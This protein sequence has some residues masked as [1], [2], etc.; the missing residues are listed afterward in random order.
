M[1]NGPKKSIL[2]RL[3][4]RQ[5]LQLLQ[6]QTSHNL[7]THD[8]SVFGIIPLAYD[9]L[10]AVVL[11]NLWKIVIKKR[12]R[13]LATVAA[14]PRC[15]PFLCSSSAII[16]WL[17]GGRMNSGLFHVACIQCSAL[18][19]TTIKPSL[20]F[21]QSLINWS[22]SMSLLIDSCASLIQNFS[23]TSTS[24]VLSSLSPLGE[25]LYLYYNAHK[26]SAF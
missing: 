19:A 21:G 17:R 1:V 14:T 10:V 24:S 8:H 5:R 4:W 6:G 15:P 9:A 12:H 18:T 23:P 11:T 13:I 25:C 16:W 26:A 3:E 20:Y 7:T 22:L 2:T